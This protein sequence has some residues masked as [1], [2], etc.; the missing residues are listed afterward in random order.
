MKEHVSAFLNNIISSYDF[1]SVFK[2]LI[3]KLEKIRQPVKIYWDNHFF[4]KS[5]Q[6]LPSINAD[7]SANYTETLLWTNYWSTLLIQWR[8]RGVLM[9]LSLSFLRENPNKLC[10]IEL[11][12]NFCDWLSKHGK[13]FWKGKPE[14][15]SYLPKNIA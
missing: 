1:R 12:Q 14:A 4:Q 3:L 6:P 11:S 10:F 13:I 7:G 8:G 2:Y 9:E 5:P 15:L